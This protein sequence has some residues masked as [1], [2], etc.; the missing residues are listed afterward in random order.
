MVTGE[1]IVT[2]RGF[3]PLSAIARDTIRRVVVPVETPRIT[4]VTSARPPR[5]TVPAFPTTR[6][7]PPHVEIL[8]LPVTRGLHAVTFTVAPSATNPAVTAPRFDADP[9]PMSTLTETSPPTAT[10]TALESNHARAAVGAIVAVSDGVIVDVAERAVGA[11]EGAAPAIETDP[12]TAMTASRAVAATPMDPTVTRTLYDDFC[13]KDACSDRLVTSDPAWAHCTNKRYWIVATWLNLSAIVRLEATSS[14]QT[15]PV[16][17]S[18]GRSSTM[19]PT[20]AS[21]GSPATPVMS[22]LNDPC[23]GVIPRHPNRC[24][25]PGPNEVNDGPFRAIWIVRTSGTNLV[26]TRTIRQ[27]VRGSGRRRD[28]CRWRDQGMIKS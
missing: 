4:K 28:A 11:I 3:R 25:L 17:G 20:T 6:R 16:T 23:T 5:E 24:Q 14:I 26:L 12:R 13:M 15:N 18:S 19:P 7:L 10:L 1:G 21:S 8:Q 9:V 22:C 27:V 2:V